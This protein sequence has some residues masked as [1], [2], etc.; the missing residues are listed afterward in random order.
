MSSPPSLSNALCYEFSRSLE[1][2]F[3]WSPPDLSISSKTCSSIVALSPSEIAHLGLNRFESESAPS[4]LFLAR[5]TS[6]EREHMSQ[7]RKTAT[8][9]VAFDLTMSPN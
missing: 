3:A 1:Q 4:N 7:Q 8:V 9:I 2:S 5:Q 6:S